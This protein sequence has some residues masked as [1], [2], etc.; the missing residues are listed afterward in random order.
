MICGGIGVIFVNMKGDK[1]LTKKEK[2][3][4]KA[5]HLYERKLKQKN[6]G[7]IIHKGDS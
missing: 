6:E 4:K 2:I 5:K 3:L 7:E 1:Q